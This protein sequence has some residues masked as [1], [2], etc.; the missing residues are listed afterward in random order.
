[1]AF[2]PI[3]ILVALIVVF[4]IFF[5]D[6]LVKRGIEKT[7]EKIFQAKFEIGYLKLSFKPLSINMRKVQ[8]ADASD[9]WKN[10]FEMDAVKM[11]IEPFPLLS[12]KVIINEMTC[13]GIE[14]GTERKTSGKLPPKKK[15]REEEK[16][17]VEKLMDSTK[18]MVTDEFSALPVSNL[19]ALSKDIKIDDFIDLNE[20]QS[21]K[22]IEEIRNDVEEKYKK[23]DE[24]IKGQKVKEEADKINRNI[25]QIRKVKIDSVEDIPKVKET[26]DRLNQ[27]KKS[28]DKINKEVKDTQKSFK[29]DVDYVKTTLK[30]IN[31]IKD[32]DYKLIIGK[33]KLESLETGNISKVIF[34]PLWVGRVN[35]ALYWV[36]MVRKYMP[37][38]GEEEK[39]EIK[40]ERRKGRDI[41]FPLKVVLPKFL[42][43][44]VDVSGGK[45]D[46]LSFEGVVND[47]TSNQALIGRP[48]KID[49]SGKFMKH[50]LSDIIFTGTIDHVTEKPKD[51]F[52]L[53]VKGIEMKG[54]SLGEVKYMPNKVKKGTVDI[55]TKFSL[56]EDYLENEINAEAKSVE[57]V[58]KTGLKKNSFEYIMNDV[59]SSINLLTLGGRLYGRPGDLKF[60]LSSNLDE[61][62]ARKIK[63]IFGRILEEAK[64]QIRAKLNSIV[65]EKRK[66]LVKIYKEKMGEL[67]EKIK[68]NAAIVQE[69]L[70]IVD[71]KIKEGQKEIDRMIEKEKKKKQQ[72][73]QKG[74]EKGLKKIF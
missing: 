41:R 74:I 12:K 68:E 1:K 52:D 31:E 63:E 29:K 22:A 35:K 44:K 67:N 9:E 45:E 6:D 11:S 5:L 17:A 69:Q 55:T 7:G 40:K 56:E 2:I 30:R 28:L 14:W 24:R 51:S 53:T 39:K 48:T 27:I 4:N 62:I 58:T 54:A 26:I 33:L 73:M 34:G 21:L 64:R 72:E 47:I 46:F 32:S 16:G 37:P 36:E 42:V 3:A 8:A 20:L 10:L 43:R 66:E 65:E 59:F 70:D 57:F 38:K 25:K 19:D 15:K 49:L 61:V 71:A 13:S 23:W 50:K 18:E 60:K